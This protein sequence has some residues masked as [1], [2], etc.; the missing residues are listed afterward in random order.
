MTTSQ[1][2]AAG[3][4]FLV[5]AVAL[6]FVFGLVFDSYALGIGPAIAVGVGVGAAVYF[7]SRKS[8]NGKPSN[9]S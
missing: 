3:F 6:S 2:V 9:R 7:A 1:A 8:S 5:T 4:T